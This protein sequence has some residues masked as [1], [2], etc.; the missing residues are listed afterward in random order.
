MRITGLNYIRL[1]VNE[2][3]DSHVFQAVTWRSDASLL[4]Q[5]QLNYLPSS[6]ET[7]TKLNTVIDLVA[8]KH[9][10]LKILEIDL[11]DKSTTSS[12]FQGCDVSTRAAYSWYDFA[13]VDANTL[14]SVQMTYEIKKDSA[15]HLISLSKKLLNL[16]VIKPTYDLVIVK[17]LERTDINVE[18]IINTLKP[19]L[20]HDVFTL[21][22]PLE[23]QINGH[24]D[25]SKLDLISSKFP[26]TSSKA[27]SD[28]T[29]DQI[30]PSSLS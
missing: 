8:H 15:F 5:N 3:P 16:S 19:M 28:S 17:A 30:F 18:E 29:S 27:S 11:D 23:S 10:T 25:V 22:I 24:V 13:T 21:V 6:H 7:T 2:K 1:D 9:L 12:W 20:K 4:T 26:D 14:V